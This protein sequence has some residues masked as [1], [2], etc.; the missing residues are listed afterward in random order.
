[1]IFI[2]QIVLR[3]FKVIVFETF[4]HMSETSLRFEDFDSLLLASWNCIDSH[5]L[6]FVNI[7]SPT[8]LTF[9]AK[10]NIIAV[11]VC[12]NCIIWIIG[13]CTDTCSPIC[14]SGILIKFRSESPTKFDTVGWSD[15]V[16]CSSVAAWKTFSTVL[17]TTDVFCVGSY[18]IR[19]LI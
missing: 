15:K 14:D 4:C 19:T 5:I 18:W 10:A 16:K 13:S 17:I 8:V 1:M 7:G 12:R 3:N 9:I 6:N 2:T 11:S